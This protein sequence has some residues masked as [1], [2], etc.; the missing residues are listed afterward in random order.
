MG[1]MARTPVTRRELKRRRLPALAAEQGLSVSEMDCNE[2]DNLLTQVEQQAHRTRDRRAIAV[3]G[4][5]RSRGRDAARRHDDFL[6]SAYE[7]RG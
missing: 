3:A 5:F 1:A 6:V 7:T 2:I 4:R